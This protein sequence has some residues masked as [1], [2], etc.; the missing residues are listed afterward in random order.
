MKARF[1][2]AVAAVTVLVPAVCFAQASTTTGVVGG[3]VA[4]AVV[5]GPVGAV[6]GGVIG[7]T[8][9]S[10]AEPP[11]EVYNYVEEDQMPS[12]A[13][14]ERLAVGEPLPETVV[15]RRVPQHDEWGY[16]VVN[17]HRVIIDN[18]SR[19]IVKVIE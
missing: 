9:G 5:G 16:A 1:V 7:G 8:I 13:Y 4:G 17:N 10:A 18:R 3:A 11:R 15:V 6:V 19:K 12:V 2:M 14:Q